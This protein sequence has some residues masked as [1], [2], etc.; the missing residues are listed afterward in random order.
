MVTQPSRAPSAETETSYAERVLE[1]SRGLSKGERTRA[2]IQAAACRLLDDAPPRELTVGAVAA[3]A[4]LSQGAFYVYFA[5]R[6]ALLE[7]VLIGFVAHLQARMRS[8]GH[9]EPDDPARAATRVYVALFERNRGLM[10]CLVHHLDGFEEARAAFHRLNKE[11]LETVVRAAERNWRRE[12]RRPDR[13]ELMR[14][15]YAL[16]GMVDQYLSNLFLSVDPT[17]Q[18]LSADRAATIETLVD[19]W[20]RGM[21][22]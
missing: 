4:D 7:T 20:E 10:R 22:P 2:R 6:A 8:A 13:A 19:I 21:R 12:G 16:G 17:V 1:E 14:R 5:D 3:A 18:A 11:W 9:A 15:A